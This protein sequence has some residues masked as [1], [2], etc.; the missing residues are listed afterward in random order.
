MAHFWQ[1]SPLQRSCLGCSRLLSLTCLAGCCLF[2][3]VAAHQSLAPPAVLRSSGRKD[4]ARALYFASEQS[5]RIF[6]QLSALPR[7]LPSIIFDS[8]LSSSDLP[9]AW[10][11]PQPTGAWMEPGST[12]WPSE[13]TSLVVWVTHHCQFLDLLYQCLHKWHQ[14]I[15][16]CC[17]KQ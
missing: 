17:T 13:S 15:R 7:R 1:V 3:R 14:S 16:E 5:V 8:P 11:S 10:P 9:A 2:R 6:L 4:T 12:S